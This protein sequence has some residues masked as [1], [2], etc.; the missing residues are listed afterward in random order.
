MK[1]AESEIQL[2]NV[3][4]FEFIKTIPDN[5]VKCICIDPPYNIQFN[6]VTSNTEWDTIK[7]FDKYLVDLF[8][9]IK[10]ILTDDGTCWCYMARTQTFVLNNAIEK[11][12][13]QNNLHNWMTYIRAKGRG[14]SKQF[15]S[16]CEE[17]F[18]ITKTDKYK[19]DALEYERECVTPYVTKDDKDNKKTRGWGINMETGMRVRWSGLGNACLFSSPF[20]INKFEKQIHSTQKPVLLNAMLIMISSDEGDTVYDFFSGSGSSGVASVL[21][22]RNWVGCEL[23]TEMYNKSLNWLNNID[24]EEGKNYIKKRIK[25]QKDPYPSSYTEDYNKIKEIENKSKIKSSG[26]LKNI[27]TKE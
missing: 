2:N 22:K 7:D 26:F 21:T 8:T 16:Q 18:H 14:S 4:S 13:L 3:N 23:D 10:R 19:W 1:I 24:F 17:I 15:K 6:G 25:Y 9:E 12:G 11:V 5:S 20:C 27:H